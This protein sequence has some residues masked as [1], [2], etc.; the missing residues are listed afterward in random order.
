[1]IRSAVSAPFD[2]R[3]RIERQPGAI[4]SELVSRGFRS[5]QV[6]NQ[7]KQERLRHAHDREVVVSIPY[8]IDEAVSPGHT[9]SEQVARHILERG[10]DGRVLALVIGGESFIRLVDQ[11]LDSFGRGQMSGGDEGEAVLDRSACYFHGSPRLPQTACRGSHD[12]PWLSRGEQA[13]RVL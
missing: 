8:G 2:A 5:N 6:T 7:R 1:R 3:Q 9:D 12:V 11:I 10:I 13:T 4:D